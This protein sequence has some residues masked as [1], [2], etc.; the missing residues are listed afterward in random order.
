MQLGSEIAGRI[1]FPPF[2]LT[3]PPRAAPLL[4]HNYGRRWTGLGQRNVISW[5]LKFNFE[6]VL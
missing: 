3:I 5:R 6:R 4:G 2:M 1:L